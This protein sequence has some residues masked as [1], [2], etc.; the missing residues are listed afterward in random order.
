MKLINS[1]ES[2]FDLLSAEECDVLGQLRLV[3]GDIQW[4]GRVEYCNGNVWGTVCDDFWAAPDAQVVCRQL[5]YVETGAIARSSAFFGQGVGPIHLDNVQ[6]SGSEL[7]L[8][9]CTKSTIHNC[10]HAEDA[11]VTCGGDSD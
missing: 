9:N 4:E 7:F 11:G 8:D 2:L 6:C 5:G 1:I 10:I 3:G